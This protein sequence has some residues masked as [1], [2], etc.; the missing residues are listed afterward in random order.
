M[1]FECRVTMRFSSND[2][3]EALILEFRTSI[4]RR[5]LLCTSCWAFLCLLEVW[6][7][8][9]ILQLNFRYVGVPIGRCLV[10]L[11]SEI[12]P[13]LED[14]FSPKGPPVLF[15]MIWPL[16]APD[17]FVVKW[18]GQALWNWAV[19]TK[20]SCTVLQFIW[21]QLGPCILSGCQTVM[22]WLYNVLQVLFLWLS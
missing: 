7:S 8:V 5:C 19:C 15:C 22:T 4:G 1:F 18:F 13:L 21:I 10:W 20:L 3:I 6:R 16:D 2:K 11:K 14:P 17:A 9:Y 12:I